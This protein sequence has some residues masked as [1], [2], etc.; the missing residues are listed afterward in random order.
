M[1]GNDSENLGARAAV[2]SSYSRLN[3]VLHARAKW[4]SEAKRMDAQEGA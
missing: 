3:F 2:V 4:T 1:A